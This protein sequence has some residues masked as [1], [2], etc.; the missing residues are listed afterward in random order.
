M[1]MKLVFEINGKEIELTMEEA[2][3]LRD[4][5]DGL[6]SK[7]VESSPVIIP[8]PY[9]PVPDYRRPWIEPYYPVITCGGS[10]TTTTSDTDYNSLN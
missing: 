9:Y 3:E 6:F 5:I 2:R 1:L 7:P 10:D 4:Q 8:Y